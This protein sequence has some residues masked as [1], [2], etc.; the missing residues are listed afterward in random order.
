MLCL[1]LRKPFER[2]IFML[3]DKFRDSMACRY[4]EKLQQDLKHGV[5]DVE[6]HLMPII[7]L[8]AKGRFGVSEQQ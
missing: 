7:L 5:M 4:M 8:I 6:S 2:C 1:A 3:P